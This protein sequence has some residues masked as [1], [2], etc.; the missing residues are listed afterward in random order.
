M[1][2]IPPPSTKKENSALF[3]GGEKKKRLDGEGKKGNHEFSYS[4]SGEREKNN[5]HYSG[6]RMSRK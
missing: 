6:Q 3:L 2:T 4:S 1:R 5:L